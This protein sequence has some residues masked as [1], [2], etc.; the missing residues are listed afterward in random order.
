MIAISKEEVTIIACNIPQAILMVH[1][2]TVEEI[3]KIE[4]NLDKVAALTEIMI[5][6]TKRIQ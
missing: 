2:Q 6:L 4:P 1:Q 3:G 5:L